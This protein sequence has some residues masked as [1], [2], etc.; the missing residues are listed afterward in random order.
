MG[1]EIE[2][3]LGVAPKYVKGG[4]GDLNVIADGELVFSKKERGRWPEADELIRALEKLA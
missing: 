2:K 4:G 1:A 3:A